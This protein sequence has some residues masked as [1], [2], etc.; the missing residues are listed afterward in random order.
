MIRAFHPYLQPGELS[1]L[2]NDVAT[3]DAA[4]DGARAHG[5]ALQFPHSPRPAVRFAAANPQLAQFEAGWP[6][7]G[8]RF[9]AL[10]RTMRS[11]RADSSARSI[12]AGCASFMAIR[13][14]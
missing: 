6:A 14:W 10:L 1:R 11:T 8:H 7:I 12:C 9:D 4:F 13:C 2:S 5:P 3:L